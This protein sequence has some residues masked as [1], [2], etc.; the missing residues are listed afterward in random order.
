MISFD[1]MVNTFINI[2][3][4]QA[5]DGTFNSVKTLLQEGPP[6][7]LKDQNEVMIQKWF[8]NLKNDDREIVLE[9]IQNTI[10]RVVFNLL[11]ILDNKIGYP[12]KGVESDFTLNLQIYKNQEDLFN[13]HPEQIFRI[14]RSYSTD[15]DLHD[16][17]LSQIKQKNKKEDQAID[18]KE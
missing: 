9:I 2:I 10:A 1:E 4:S 12:I 5:V 7:R 14:N 13:Y 17:F 15:G 8:L 3:I 6:G 18:E 16:M 11:V